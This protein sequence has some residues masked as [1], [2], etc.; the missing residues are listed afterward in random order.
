MGKQGVSAA[1]VAALLLAV[2]PIARGAEQQTSEQTRTTYKQRVEPIC[3]RD[4]VRSQRILKGA[5]A[6]IKHQ[7]LVPA[8]HQF[9]RVSNTF[10]KSIK[11][12]VRVPRPPADK[13]RLR[14]WFHFLR[15][16]KLRMHKLGK[17]LVEKK[18]TKATHTSIQAERSGNAANNVTF[19]FGFHYCRLTREHFH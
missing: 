14:K 17:Y 7:K 5:E 4:T 16:V 2:A 3:R 12:L 15:L 10:G 8:G 11:Q 9:L 18:R 19:P 1:I 6:R 13:A